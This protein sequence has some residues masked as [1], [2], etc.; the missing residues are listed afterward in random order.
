MPFKEPLTFFDRAEDDVDQRV[1]NLMRRIT[2]EQLKALKELDSLKSAYYRDAE[3]V[4][5]AEATAYLAE[6][7][8]DPQTGKS[9]ALAGGHILLRG[10]TL[11]SLAMA[12]IMV[13]G[14]VQGSLPLESTRFSDDED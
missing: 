13:F 1:A 2:P 8:V 9:I 5:T 14:T 3:E 10:I 11:F 4:I 6:E 7:G 12:E